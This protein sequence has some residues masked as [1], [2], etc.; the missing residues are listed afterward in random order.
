MRT[1]VRPSVAPLFLSATDFRDLDDKSK[2]SKVM[3][4]VDIFW[5]L[6]VLVGSELRL[7]VMQIV[8]NLYM[9]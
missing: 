2:E 3:V 4:M 1:P 8:H 9:D 6:T 5:Y 7:L